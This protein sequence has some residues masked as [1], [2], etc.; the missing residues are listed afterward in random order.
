ME[1]IPQHTYTYGD[2]LPAYK[3]GEWPGSKPNHFIGSKLILKP[4]KKYEKDFYICNARHFPQ[5]YS[6]EYKFK[7]GVKLI[8]P[9]IH[10]D[11]YKPKKRP[12]KPIITE[13]KIFIR[14]R[15]FNPKD[16]FNNPYAKEYPLLQKKKRV[17]HSDQILTEYNIE[18]IMSRKKRIF[19]L[20][21]QRNFF[22]TCKP[23]DKN[24]TC[25]ENCADF[26]KMEGLVPGSTNSINLRKT[27]RKGED[28]FY[29]TMDLNIKIL[30]K[31]KIWGVRE[32]MES[33]KNDKKYV[34]DLNNWESKVFENNENNKD[35][36]K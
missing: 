21:Q 3:S 24:Y 23:G 29:Q 9:Y 16:N 14:N 25:V 2:G 5:K 26:F 19:S 28:N 20:D 10:E 18:G 12:L 11:I 36:K 17:Q 32:L 15:S 22:K 31:N 34:I 4:I 35:N 13:P 6:E 27:Q 8:P 7:K 33:L 1:I 30:N